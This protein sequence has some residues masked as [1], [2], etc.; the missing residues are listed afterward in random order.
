M[1]RYIIKKG[2]FSV[3]FFS[4]ASVIIFMIINTYL[5]LGNES[6]LH[7]RYFEWMKN[8]LRFEFGYSKKYS[9]P[10]MVLIESRIPRT[11]LLT[12]ASLAVSM[13]IGLLI[14]FISVSKGN[15]KVDGAVTLFLLVAMVVPLVFIFWTVVKDFMYLQQSYMEFRAYEIKQ[16]IIF[17]IENMTGLSRFIFSV[18]LLSLI[19]ALVYTRYIRL[20]ILKAFGVPYEDTRKVKKYVLIGKPQKLL[21]VVTALCLLQVPCLFFGD[22][23]TET[24]FAWQGVGRLGYEAVKDKDYFILIGVGMLGLML[25]FVSNFFA[26]IL[27]FSFHK[28]D[29]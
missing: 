29:D 23:I 24:L 4:L 14:G 12:G 11:L 28:N 22:L 20:E 2:F 19:Q 6:V 10:V 13:S 5:E 27:F 8:V 7:L 18:F 17:F 21:S 9:D 15:S 25:I 26:D 3:L 16:K 1:L